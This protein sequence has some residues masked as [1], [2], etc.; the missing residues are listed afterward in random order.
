ML[1][2]LSVWNFSVRPKSFVV[3]VACFQDV[4]RAQV[5]ILCQTPLTPVCL[6]TRGRSVTL[7]FHKQGSF[8]HVYP[9]LSSFN[10]WETRRSKEPMGLHGVLM[11]NQWAVIIDAPPSVLRSEVR[12]ALRPRPGTAA[13]KPGTPLVPYINQALSIPPL[14]CESSTLSVRVCKRDTHTPN[15]GGK[16]CNVLCHSSCLGL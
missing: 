4:Q 8:C 13:L 11:S 10:K 3:F 12:T 16:M 1:H 6:I 5:H 9:H 7:R 14:C 2:Q 15:S